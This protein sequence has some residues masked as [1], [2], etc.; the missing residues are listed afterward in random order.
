MDGAPSGA[1]PPSFLCF[2]FV[3]VVLA[4]LGCGCIARTIFRVVIAGAWVLPA[5]LTVHKERDE[6]EQIETDQ[7]RANRSLVFA[8]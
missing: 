7:V 5:A 1:P 4:R 8:V 2:F 3:R 6:S